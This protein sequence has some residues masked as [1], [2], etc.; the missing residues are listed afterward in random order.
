[1]ERNCMFICG[2]KVVP[3]MNVQMLVCYILTVIIVREREY[4]M[5]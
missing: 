1:M 2:H 5:F 3:D 4:T